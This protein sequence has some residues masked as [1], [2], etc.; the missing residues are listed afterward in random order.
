ADTPSALWPIA[1][2]SLAAH[3]IK[4]EKDGRARRA[5]AGWISVS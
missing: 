1:Q 2:M 3:L 4:L 5:G